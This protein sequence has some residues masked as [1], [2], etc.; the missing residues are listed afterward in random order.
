LF[1]LARLWRAYGNL[2]LNTRSK[3]ARGVSLARDDG[4]GPPV[5][6][7]KPQVFAGISA[8]QFVRAVLRATLDQ[9]LVNASAVAA[10]STDEEHIHQLRVGLRRLR[11]A[12]RELAP[13]DDR[14]VDDWEKPLAH[15]FALLGAARD[16]VT[17]ARA[18]QPLLEVAGAPR[19]DWSAALDVDPVAVVQDGH[20]QA[21]L[22]DLLS[23]AL[24]D[25]DGPRPR[26]HADLLAFL[27]ER[28]SGLHRRIGRAAQR[29]ERLPLEDQHKARKRLKRLRYLAEF[30]GPLYERG[31][32]KR[33]L[34]HLEPA[35]DA[36]GKHVDIAVAMERFR[37]QADV[38]APALFAA[39]YL[40]GYLG[41]TARLAHAALQ[42][43][44]RAQ[45]FWNR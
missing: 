1:E 6:A 41:N 21:V 45:P 35:Q 34:A 15:A 25:D 22:L 33:Y 38:D 10:G 9:V 23:F 36:L 20:F 28:L 12:L 18:V 42:E 7:R 43:P 39:R 30:A 14:I 8:T 3:A 16:S 13:L 27:A 2:W 17:A 31:A 37:R 26:T 4:F 44:A 24:Q 11:T 19:V 40:E 32:V 5:R 29:F